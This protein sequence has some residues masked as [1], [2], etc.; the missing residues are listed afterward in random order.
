MYRPVK[1]I[2]ALLFIA[3]LALFLS[4]CGASKESPAPQEEGGAEPTAT[5]QPAT[6]SVLMVV[7]QDGF[8]DTEYNTVRQALAGAGFE[9]VVAAPEKAVATGV[10]GTRVNPDLALTEVGASGYLAVVF[11]GGP[12]TDSL[13]D[14]EEAHRLAREALQQGKVLAAICLAPAIL[15]RAGVLSGKRATVF[16]SAKGDLTAGGAIYT[17]SDV[18]VDGKVVTASGPEASGP[19]AQAILDSLR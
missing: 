7:C 2:L 17:G 14:T 3:V 19:F 13:F 18:E 6:E 16:P 11:I 4:S 10:S 9:V 5:Q 1:T 12:G 15:A 8:Q